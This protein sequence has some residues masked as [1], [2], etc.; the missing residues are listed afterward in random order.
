LNNSYYTF[1]IS[2]VKYDQTSQILTFMD[3]ATGRYGSMT[4]DQYNSG[5]IKPGSVIGIKGYKPH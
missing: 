2:F 4:V 5:I 1:G 3:P